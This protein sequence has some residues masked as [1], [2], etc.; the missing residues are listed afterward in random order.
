MIYV[1]SFMTAILTCMAL[2]ALA[3]SDTSARS[4][5]SVA[6]EQNASGIIIRVAINEQGQEFTEQS[7]IR[8][9]TGE[10]AI[11]NSEEVSTAWHQAMPIDH[12][13]NLTIAF[14]EEGDSSTRW[15]RHR[16]GV[17]APGF[18]YS[19]RPSFYFNWYTPVTFGRP[20]YWSVYQPRPYFYGYRYYYYPRT[21]W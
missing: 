17:A 3:S 1:K 11:N 4:S 8:M 21:W 9:M 14:D 2:P 6:T 19:A 20:N 13:P 7:E 10:T 5:S 15:A 12:N 16:R 18:Y